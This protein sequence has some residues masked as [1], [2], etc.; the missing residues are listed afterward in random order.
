M[1]NE[2]SRSENATATTTTA[3]DAP[4]TMS[5]GARILIEAMKTNPEYFFHGHKYSW[6][7]QE[8]GGVRTGHGMSTRDHAVIKAAYDRYIVEAFFTERV[9]TSTLGVEDDEGKMRFKAEG[10]YAFGHTDPRV[11]LMNTAQATE[12]QITHSIINTNTTT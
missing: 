2:S 8:L 3:S 1:N 11:L 10:R 9:I 6:V 12:A 7:K 5:E 4:D